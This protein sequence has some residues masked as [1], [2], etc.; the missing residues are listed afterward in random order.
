MKIALI[1]TDIREKLENMKKLNYII[2]IGFAHLN[3]FFSFI[4]TT[5]ACDE[6]VRIF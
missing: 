6:R 1:V 3:I 2:A 5:Q 4:C